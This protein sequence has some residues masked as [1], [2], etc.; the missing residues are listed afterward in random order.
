MKTDKKAIYIFSS[1]DSRPSDSLEAQSDE[2]RPSNNT[3]DEK[4]KIWAE[5]RGSNIN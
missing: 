1:T 5:K 3:S 4:Y 2:K